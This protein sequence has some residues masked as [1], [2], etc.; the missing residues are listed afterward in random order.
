MNKINNNIRTNFQ[1]STKDN[2]NMN[3][4]KTYNDYFYEMLDKV[5][6]RAEME[7]PPYGDF[8]P[9]YEEFPNQDPN[10]SIDRFKLEVIKLPKHIEPDPKQ[11]FIQAVVYPLAGDYKAETYLAKGEKD[12]IM[13]ELSS[14]DFPV[15][16]NNAFARLT[17]I[18]ENPD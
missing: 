9:V 3:T 10:L 6:K 4:K 18:I 1:A 5:I 7:V 12:E 11:R 2:G 15:K 13:K 8:V 16:L 17:D 14:K